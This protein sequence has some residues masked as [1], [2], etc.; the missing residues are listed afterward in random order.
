MRFARAGALHPHPADPVTAHRVNYGLTRR[1]DGGLLVVFDY[2]GPLADLRISTPQVPLTD[3]LWRHTCAEL[4]VGSAGNRSYREFNFSPSGQWAFYD[5]SDYRVRAVGSGPYS[6][7]L[8][9]LPLP[10]TPRILA[11]VHPDGL[12]LEVSLVAAA[13][14]RQAP[15]QI[16]LS[17]VLEAADGHLSYWALTHAAEQPDFHR[18]EAFS[19]SLAAESTAEIHA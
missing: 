9:P 11:H 17:M 4:F 18:R 1:D 10:P 14:P 8:P 13:L 7:P 5:F 12:R 2:L 16:G 6:L 15:L 19:L 3:D